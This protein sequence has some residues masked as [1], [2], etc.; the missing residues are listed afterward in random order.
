MSIAVEHLSLKL[1]PDPSR[2]IM[3]AFGTGSVNRS[4]HTIN[5]VLKYPEPE[6][7]RLLA[8]LA[9]DFESDHPR[10]FEVFGDHYELIRSNLPEGQ[11][12]T[13]SRQLLLGACFTMEY[14][15]ESVALFNPSIVP[16]LCRRTSPRARC[17]S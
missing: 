10:L 9:S 13:R 15:L 6:V 14:A 3:R 7:E 17:D 5:R 12:L 8:G 2:V 16:A 11:E 4:C 1:E